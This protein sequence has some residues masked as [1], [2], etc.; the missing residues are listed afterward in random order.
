GWCAWRCYAREAPFLGGTT[1]WG[2]GRGAKRRRSGGVGWPGSGDLA[3]VGGGGFAGLQQAQPGSGSGAGSPAVQ[4]A[5]R[6]VAG[7]LDQGDDD[8]EQG[9]GDPH[10]A[11]FEAL[12]AVADGEVA[13]SA[14][15][16]GARHG[17]VADEGDDRGGGAGDQ[18]GQRLGDEDLADDRPGAA[19]HRLDGLDEPV[20]DLAHGGLDEPGEEGD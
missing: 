8:G 16:D 18:R 7:E 4:G 15:A 12:V 1:P 11:G 14:A 19:A 20:V 10:Q 3:D 5:G 17:G 2:K 9:H 13:E 6:V